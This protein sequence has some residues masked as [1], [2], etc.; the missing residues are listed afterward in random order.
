M[1]YPPLATIDDIE[2]RAPTLTL[3]ETQAEALL[4]DAS[5]IIR[6]YAGRTWVDDAGT[7]LSG[8][9][10]GVPGMAAMM[11][12]RALRNDGFSQEGIGDYSVNYGAQA[13]DRLFLTKADKL[14]LRPPGQA[15]SVD[16]YGDVG[17]LGQTDDED[18]TIN[19]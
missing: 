10:D 16:T 18:W 13:A 1:A 7:A 9:P 3:N 4:V 11:V 5:A 19:D 2:A 14:Q 12:I 15:F 17:Y 8:V 6:A